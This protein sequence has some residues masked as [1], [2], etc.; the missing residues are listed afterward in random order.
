MDIAAENFKTRDPNVAAAVWTSGGQFVG[1]E[2]LSP[3][4]I[5]FLFSPRSLCQ[6]AA[7]DFWRG[8]LT[9]NARDFVDKQRALKDAMFAKMRE[10]N[11][12]GEGNWK[13]TA[14]PPERG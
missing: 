10:K 3:R 4:T 1:V 8:A 2:P 13:T 12:N 9:V 11:G 14:T 7:D 5:T 6:S